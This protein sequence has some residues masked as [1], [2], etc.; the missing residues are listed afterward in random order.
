[1]EVLEERGV[2]PG[3]EMWPMITG[4]ECEP[5]AVKAVASGK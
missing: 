2:V 3:S 1:M 5:E 4:V